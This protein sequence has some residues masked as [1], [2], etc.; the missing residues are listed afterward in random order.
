MLIGGAGGGVGSVNNLSSISVVD[1]LW[2][3][4]TAVCSDDCGLGLFF[5]VLITEL[6]RF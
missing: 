3:K 5:C 2:F 4:S 6:R 1:S